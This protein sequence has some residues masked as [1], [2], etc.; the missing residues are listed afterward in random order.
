MIK[1]D[2]LKPDADNIIGKIVIIHPDFKFEAVLR[3][4]VYQ[5]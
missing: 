3:P 1:S 2:K 5:L 4:R